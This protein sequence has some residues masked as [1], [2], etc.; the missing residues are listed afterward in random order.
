MED[1]AR[2]HC[3]PRPRSVLRRPLAASAAALATALAPALGWPPAGRAGLLK[4]VLMLM[5]PQL[6]QRLSRLCLTLAADGNPQLENA[7][8]RPCQKLATPA[9]HCLVEETD[10]SGR[11]MVVI[12]ELLSG[13]IGEASEEVLKRCAAR[14]LNLP[15]NSFQEV[16]L[17]ELGKRLRSQGSAGSGATAPPPPGGDGR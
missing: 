14:L 11:E 17:S 1:P 10:A 16:P 13:R 5:R 2:A 6:E 3:G 15:R 7:L 4:P 8:R 12:G 9:S